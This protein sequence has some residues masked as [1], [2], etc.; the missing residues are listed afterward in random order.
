MPH[1][2]QDRWMRP[3]RP[4]PWR[5]A[6]AALMLVLASYVLFAAMIIAA[7]GALP[8]A[9]LWLAG[10]VLVITSALRLLRVGFWVS[11]R[12]LR[13]SGL[14]Y[15]IT[16]PWD[17]VGSVRTVQQPV[18]VLGLPRTVQGQALVVSRLDGRVLRP[19]MTDHNADFLGR[20][21]AFDMA[22]DA[23]EG[24]ATELR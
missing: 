1:T 11:G 18:K 17:G 20:T 6:T 19:L 22:A 4:G 5:V 23:I 7:T 16:V 13:Q 14:F 8:G 24:W 15:T 9:G 10:G 3:Y 21:E 2:A 12:G